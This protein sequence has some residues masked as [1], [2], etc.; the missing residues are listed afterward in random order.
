[1]RI[2]VFGLGHVGRALLASF[3]RVRVP[4]GARARLVLAADG[5]GAYLGEDLD[6]AAVTSRK[7]ERDYD[8]PRAEGQET[9]SRGVRCRV[10]EV[11]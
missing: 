8:R 9:Q 6:P 1:M 4:G 7:L 10:T 5:Q 2:S 3:Q 11:E